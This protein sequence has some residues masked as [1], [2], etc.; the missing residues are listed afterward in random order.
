MGGMEF[1]KIFAAILV[2]GIIAMLGGFVAKQLVH[3]HKLEKDAFTVE[4]MEDAGAGGAAAA[5][6]PDPILALIATADAAKGEKIAK[7]CAACHTFTKGGPNGVGPN[8]YG[9]VGGPKDHIAGFA[10]SGALLETGGTTWTYAELNK[11]LWKPKAY[12]PATKMSFAGVKKPEDRA[13]LIA[14]LRSQADAPKPL[15]SDAEIA[16]ET[17]ELGP[18]EAPA[19]EDAADVPSTDAAVGDKPVSP[20]AAKANEDAATPDVPATSPG[21]KVAH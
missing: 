9:V 13:A 7:A 12:A 8:L 2:A 17:A 3:P 14:W 16:A 15:P 5:A 21:Q 4:A 11:F 18:K 1:N 19:A 10:Y 6:G 20:A